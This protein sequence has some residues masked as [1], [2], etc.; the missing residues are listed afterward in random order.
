MIKLFEIPVYA[1]TK[2]KFD[3]KIDKAKEI[4]TE[5]Y[6]KRHNREDEATCIEEYLEYVFN[7]YQ[8]WEYNHII[9]VIVISLEGR[10]VCFYIYKPYSTIEKYHWKSR[11]KVYL[12]EQQYG[13]L[14]FR[15]SEK[16]TNESV[17]IKTKDMLDGIAHDIFKKNYVDKEAFINV[18]ANIDYMKMISK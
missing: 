6:L 4:E 1:W 5:A 7:S 17:R 10:D 15:I 14:H 11:K 18:N 12:R 8:I 9:G 3:K 16:D 2:E 13:G